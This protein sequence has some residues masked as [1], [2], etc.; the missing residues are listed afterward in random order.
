MATYIPI[1]DDQ[2]LIDFREEFD[3]IVPGDIESLR[4]F[5]LKY[6]ELISTELIQIMRRS[7]SVVQKI[8]SRIR[9]NSVLIIE[10]ENGVLTTRR[11]T[12]KFISP[13]LTID[14]SW[15]YD[16][17]VNKNIGIKALAKSIG[18]SRTFI[19]KRL[20][21]LGV[22]NNYVKNPYYNK[23]WLYEHYMVQKQSMRQCGKI[24]GVSHCTIRLW[25]AE[26]GIPS[27]DPF[28]TSYVSALAQKSRKISQATANRG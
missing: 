18:R 12:T 11:N 23:E 2:E 9:V 17:H 16:Q 21:S 5:F 4:D 1:M 6:P 8:R 15:L 14:P 7:F 3:S 10:T 28:E 20:R 26:F 27:R 19:R 13:E 24:A 22:T 25:L